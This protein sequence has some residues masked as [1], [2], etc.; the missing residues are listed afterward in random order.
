MKLQQSNDRCL[1]KLSPK[2]KDLS[3]VKTKQTK[4]W[5]LTPELLKKS[6]CGSFV[7]QLHGKDNG[8]RCC[9]SVQSGS[10]RPGHNSAQWT[11]RYPC[12]PKPLSHDFLLCSFRMITL[13]KFCFLF[14]STWNIIFGT[15]QIG[16]INWKSQIYSLKI[17][18]IIFSIFSRNWMS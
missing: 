4:C 17:M 12:V 14:S 8:C 1:S 11:V 18:K 6:T 3:L 2:T 13:K 7:D 5:S 15:L 16:K 10:P 9:N